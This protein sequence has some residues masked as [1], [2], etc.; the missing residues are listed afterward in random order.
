M[1][2]SFRRY[3]RSQ[4]WHATSIGMMVG[5]PMKNSEC[6]VQDAK[7]LSKSPRAHFGYTLGPILSQSSTGINPLDFV[8]DPHNNRR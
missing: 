1:S 8:V 7:H 2:S 3:F 5:F 4:L 6:R